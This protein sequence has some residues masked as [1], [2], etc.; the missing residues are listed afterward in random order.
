MNAYKVYDMAPFLSVGIPNYN[1][2]HFLERCVSAVMLQDR[3]P[4]EVLVYDDGS[5]DNSMEVLRALQTRWPRLR[6][7][8]GEKN[9][10]VTGAINTLVSLLSGE[11]IALPAADDMPLPGFYRLAEQEARRYPQA[12]VI[13]G[14]FIGVEEDGTRWMECADR[15]IDAGYIA[16][17]DMLWKLFHKAPALFGLGFTNIW[18]R[19]ALLAEGGYVPELK[20]YSD[21]QLFR[22]IAARYGAVYLGAAPVACARASASTYSGHAR[23][24]PDIYLPV[25]DKAAQIM[26]DQYTDLFPERY[27]RHWERKAREELGYARMSPARWCKLAAAWGARKT[28]SWLTRRLGR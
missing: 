11:W 6:I 10:G 13:F 18:R 20:W 24:N 19:D 2:A 16:P 3:V 22:I 9:L 17:A 25:L 27:I 4:D 14:S 8:R 5:T 12:G 23:A 26:R 15:W 21:E 1:H 7:E 28:A